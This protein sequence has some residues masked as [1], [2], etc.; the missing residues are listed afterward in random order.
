MLPPFSGNYD[1]GIG[2][3]GGTSASASELRRAFNSWW[4]LELR[5]TLGCQKSRK[6]NFAGYDLW[7]WNMPIFTEKHIHWQS[8]VLSVDWHRSILRVQMV[9]TFRV[10]PH[11]LTFP[12][13]RAKA[14]KAKAGGSWKKGVLRGWQPWDHQT[15]LCVINHPIAFFFKTKNSIWHHSRPWLWTLEFVPGLF[16]KTLKRQLRLKGHC[17]WGIRCSQIM[18]CRIGLIVPCELSA[19][20]DCEHFT[21]DPAAS[22]F[23]RWRMKPRVWLEHWT[24]YDA[25]ELDN[26]CFAF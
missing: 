7:L 24:E 4:L 20:V 1:E 19:F 17:F 15:G 12:H 5:D 26:K 3:S 16:L 8:P 6:A 21:L 25:K 18:M 14:A 13:I 9:A 10:H 2:Y 23:E 22:C 11:L